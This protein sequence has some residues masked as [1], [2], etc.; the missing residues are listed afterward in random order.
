MPKGIVKPGFHIIAP[1]ATIA[2]VVEKRV[3]HKIFVLSD[4]SDTV[5]PY[6]RRCRWIFGFCLSLLVH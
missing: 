5:F 2:T 4:G 3:R 1:V 6:D